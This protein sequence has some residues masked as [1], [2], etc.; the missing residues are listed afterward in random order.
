MIIIT[1][2]ISD[3][4]REVLTDMQLLDISLKQVSILR[5]SIEKTLSSVSFISI[6]LSF[7]HPSLSDDM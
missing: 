1:I 6:I 7:P 4:V 5:C 3:K 2:I